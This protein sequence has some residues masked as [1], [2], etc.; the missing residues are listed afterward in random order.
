MN[1]EISGAGFPVRARETAPGGGC[2]GGAAATA[3]PGGRGVGIIRKWLM[4]LLLG[5]NRGGNN[6][7]QPIAT[8]VA[9]VLRVPVA[10]SG[11]LSRVLTENNRK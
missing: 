7:K 6:G 9:V 2:P 5:N 11:Q 8:I 1:Y 3:L 4:E 10:R